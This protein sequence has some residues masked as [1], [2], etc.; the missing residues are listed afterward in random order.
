[1]ITQFKLLEF[2]YAVTRFDLYK[3][4]DIIKLMKKLLKS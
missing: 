3:K 1:M 2:A 4:I